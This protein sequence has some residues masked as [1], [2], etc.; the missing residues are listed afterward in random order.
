MTTEISGLEPLILRAQAGDSQA[1][2]QLLER[3]QGWVLALC[4]ACLR[5]PELARDA[6]Q[7]ALIESFSRLEQLR[8]PA[9]FAGWLRRVVVKHCDRQTRRPCPIPIGDAGVDAASSE[10]G[11]EQELVQAQRDALARTLIDALP[12]HERVVVALHYLAGLPLR[13][14]PPCTGISRR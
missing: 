2:A 12:E 10:P 1:Q 6:S 9:A 11:V 4:L 7:E 8:E 3:V 14:S 13:M 5:S